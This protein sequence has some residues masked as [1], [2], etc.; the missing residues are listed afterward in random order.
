MTIREMTVLVTGA[1]GTVG[2]GVTRQL[3][4]GMIN[5]DAPV[6]QVVDEI[7]SGAERLLSGW[8]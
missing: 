5:D 8:D 6:V 3:L 7:R 1:T 4:A 2:S